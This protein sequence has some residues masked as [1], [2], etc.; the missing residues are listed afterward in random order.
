MLALLQRQATA[1]IVKART[2]RGTFGLLSPSLKLRESHTTV[3]RRPL[4]VSS[5]VLA[6]LQVVQLQIGRAHV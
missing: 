3:T 5:V 6:L 2:V 1:S 4:P